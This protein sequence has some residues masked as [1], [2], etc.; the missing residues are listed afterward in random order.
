MLAVIQQA[1]AGT[2]SHHSCSAKIVTKK[3]PCG[4]ICMALRWLFSSFRVGAIVMF[5]SKSFQYV[6]STLIFC[7]MFLCTTSVNAGTPTYV[8]P[9]D[10]SSSPNATNTDVKFSSVDAAISAWVAFLNQQAL[11]GPSPEFLLQLST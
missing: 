7:I 5:I 3:L 4:K 6:F 10:Y 2:L 8:G 11:N 9:Y 1:F